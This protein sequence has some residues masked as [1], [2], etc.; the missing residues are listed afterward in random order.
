M[1][2]GRNVESMI[3]AGLRVGLVL[4]VLLYLGREARSSLP[5]LWA[6]ARR[7]LANLPFSTEKLLRQRYGSFYDLVK[8]GTTGFPENLGPKVREG[9]WLRTG[10]VSQMRLSLDPNIGRVTDALYLIQL[11]RD[12]PPEVMRVAYPIFQHP[13]DA[14]SKPLRVPANTPLQMSFN[15]LITPDSLDEVQLLTRAGAGVEGTLECLDSVR[16]TAPAMGRAVAALNQNGVTV[17]RFSP[18]IPFPDFHGSSPYKLVFRFSSDVEVFVGPARLPDQI[19]E[20]GSQPFKDKELVCSVVIRLVDVR[21]YTLM[22]TLAPGCMIY[23]KT[24]VLKD[25]GIGP[26]FSHDNYA[27]IA[28]YAN[29]L[30][31]SGKVP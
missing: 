22:E 31:E 17:F 12:I 26:P 9:V 27:R 4:L 18:P 19:V 24:S 21:E 8:A 14:R 3:V 29:S 23:G 11:T 1:T 16:P 25:L 28:E 15:T 5:T 20:V 10:E 30:S 13:Q 7:T 6:S 2:A